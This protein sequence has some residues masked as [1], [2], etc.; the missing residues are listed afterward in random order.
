MSGLTGWKREVWEWVKIIV[1]AALIALFLTSCIIANSEVPSGSM[2]NTIMTGDRVI[3]SRL[4]YK[5]SDPERGDIVIFHFPDNES[6]YYVKRIIGLPGD[7]VD[8]VDG[9]VYLNGSQEPLDEPYIREPM[10][11]EEP[12]HFEVP[13]DSY[14]MLGDNRNYSADSR[15][16]Q[17]KYVKREKI[18][19]KVLFRYFPNPGKIE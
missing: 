19:A 11:P 3:G 12:M 1:T 16:W 18:I 17:N 8:I 9:H 2:E 5:F 14:F 15:K 13:E 4:S 10:I 7:T 6:L